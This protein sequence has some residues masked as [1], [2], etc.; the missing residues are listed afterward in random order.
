MYLRRMRIL[1]LV[2]LLNITVA[3]APQSA[4]NPSEIPIKHFIYI[5]QENQTFDRYFGTYPG[6]NGIPRDAKLPYRPGGP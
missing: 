5:I 6:A 3:A 1:A 2:I 4:P